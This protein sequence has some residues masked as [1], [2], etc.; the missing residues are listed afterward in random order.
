MAE[1]RF[2]TDENYNAES[3]AIEQKIVISFEGMDPVALYRS[4]YLVS[5]SILEEAH[6]Q[7]TTTPFGGITSNEIDVELLNENGIFTP[8]NQNSP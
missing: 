3:R 8:S 4:D 1:K 6:S 2:S 5:T 7:S